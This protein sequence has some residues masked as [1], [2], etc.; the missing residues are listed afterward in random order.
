MIPTEI[1]LHN[2]LVKK[3][4]YGVRRIYYIILYYI[5]EEYIM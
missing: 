2:I 5:F 3:S 4:V 1:L